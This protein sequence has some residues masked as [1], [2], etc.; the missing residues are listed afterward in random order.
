MNVMN[1]FVLPYN[2][3]PPWF[4]WLNRIVPTTWV[5]YGLSVSQLGEPCGF[6]ARVFA[7]LA[8][9]CVCVG[10][11]APNRGP[12]KS[13]TSNARHTHTARSLTLFPHTRNATHKNKHATHKN[14]ATATTTTGTVTTPVTWG[15]TTVTVQQF[16]SDVFSYEASMT[17]WTLLICVLYI[18]FFR[19]ASALALKCVFCVFLC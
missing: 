1:G 10:G 6:C 13:S 17:Y 7:C 2:L 18:A 5:V 14:T 16:L 12:L 11:V 9:V 4:K 3:I 19:V 15:A 8:C